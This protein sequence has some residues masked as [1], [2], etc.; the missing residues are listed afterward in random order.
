MTNS[1]AI[2]RL[3]LPVGGN[4]DILAAW[5]SFPEFHIAPGRQRCTRLADCRYRYEAFFNRFTAEF[6]VDEAGLVRS[7]PGYWERI[8]ESAGTKTRRRLRA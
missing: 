4:A 2:R 5:M 1:L 3:D 8:P 7:C 6:E